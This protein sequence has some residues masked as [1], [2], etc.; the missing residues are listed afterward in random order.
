MFEDQSE[1]MYE[2]VGSRSEFLEFDRGDLLPTTEK[3]R[4]V[5]YVL[6]SGQVK[7]RSQTD[8]GKEIILD[9]LG[10]G[11]VFG[12]LDQVAVDQRTPGTG[13]LGAHASEAVAISKGAAFKYDLHY[14]NDL[15]ARRPTLMVNVSRILG[16]RRKQL[17]LR[18]ARL[19]Y[20]SSLGKVAG[21][22]A[23]LGERYGSKQ[24]E[25]IRLGLRLTHQEM[26]SIVGL[27]RETVSEALAD[28]EY[29]GLIVAGRGNISLL[30]PGEL[31][32]IQ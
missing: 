8:T 4:A 22:L 2:S 23:E 26:A 1:S 29:R 31:D 3:D 7:L 28:L 6:E 24:G 15:V 27:K 25:V 10:P 5:I 14:F 17:E 9:V 16:L 20:R 18:L 13:S 32:K 30:K 21:L 11:G 12:P 19:L